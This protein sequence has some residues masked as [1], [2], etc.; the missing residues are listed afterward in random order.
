MSD[1]GLS[2]VVCVLG[3]D[4]IDSIAL[5]RVRLPPSRSGLLLRQR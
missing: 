2:D 4:L 5:R 1:A 3:L